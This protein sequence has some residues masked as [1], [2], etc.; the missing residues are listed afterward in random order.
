ME[1]LFNWIY[2]KKKTQSY[3]SDTSNVGFK[4]IGMGSEFR[5]LNLT[6]G[7]MYYP[8]CYSIE[9]STGLYYRFML[10]IDNG[11][12]IRV[13]NSDIDTLFKVVRYPREELI[14]DEILL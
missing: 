10:M 7:R 11:S 2:K 4:A 14:I 3:R 5:H 1:A 9:N 13:N 6:E 8:H 12:I